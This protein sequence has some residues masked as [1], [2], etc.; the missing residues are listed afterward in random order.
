[1]NELQISVIFTRCKDVWLTLVRSHRQS[2]VVQ[3]KEWFLRLEGGYLS[4][5]HPFQIAQQNR[6]LRKFEQGQ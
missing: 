4:Y 2:T 5:L 1:M 3:R 6:R